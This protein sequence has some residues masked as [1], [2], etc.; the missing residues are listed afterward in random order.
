MHLRLAIRS[1]VKRPAY[2]LV[3]L[4]TI[5]LVVGP[6]T[7]VLAVLNVAT[8]R[9]LPFADADRLVRLFA[10]PPGLHGAAAWNPL[11]AL[12]FVRFRERQ[13]LASEVAGIWGRERTLGVGGEPE[14]VATGQVSANVIATLGTSPMRGRTFSEDEDR[15]AARVAVLSYGLWQRRFGGEDV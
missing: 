13:T 14:S 10:L 15:T 7:A 8:V 5:A 1:L 11:G 6:S 3:V 9:P 2:S 4:A 12:E